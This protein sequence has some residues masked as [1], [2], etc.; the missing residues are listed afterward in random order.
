[1]NRPR[2]LIALGGLLVIFLVL[3]NVFH[4]SDPGARGTIA[5]ISFFGFLLLTLCFVAIS[6]RALLRRGQ[7]QR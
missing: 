3:S 7:R 6:L 2:I 4:S 5:D 1:M